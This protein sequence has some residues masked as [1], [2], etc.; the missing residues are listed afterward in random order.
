MLNRIR[1]SFSTKL[2]L[3]ILLMTVTIFVVSLGVL[4]TQSRHIIRTEAVG[5]TKA[6]LNTTMQH[7]VR[8]L[9][10]I[11]NATNTC[12]WMIEQQFQ[13]E[14]ILDFTSRI[15]RLNPHIDGCSISA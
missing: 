14:Q 6:V 8:N 10:T 7:I 2:S 3:G 12:S 11:E 1:K 9:M 15:V 13:P 5:R 4:F